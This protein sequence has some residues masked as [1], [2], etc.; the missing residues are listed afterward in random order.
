MLSHKTPDEQTPFSGS[1][2]QQCLFQHREHYSKQPATT[3]LST[4]AATA[5]AT[6][7]P[8]VSSTSSLLLPSNLPPFPP[9]PLFHLFRHLSPSPHRKDERKERDLKEQINAA[10]ALRLKKLE[11]TTHALATQ[12]ESL[13]TVSHAFEKSSSSSLT[14]RYRKS[15]GGGSDS[16]KT[17]RRRAR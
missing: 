6:A 12:L 11:R 8:S 3:S 4:T 13:S 16:D 9:S 2:M 10:A 15:S 14:S 17:Y 7:V 5:T 1:C